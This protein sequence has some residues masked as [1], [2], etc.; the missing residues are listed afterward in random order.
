MRIVLTLTDEEC[1]REP[2][3]D[4]WHKPE[5]KNIDDANDWAILHV[6]TYNALFDT[7][8]KLLKVEVE[9]EG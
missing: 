4:V 3:P 8:V 7:A 2:W 9:E 5:I 6:R 1:L